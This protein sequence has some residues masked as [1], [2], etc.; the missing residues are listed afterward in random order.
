[1]RKMTV[2]GKLPGWTLLVPIAWCIASVAIVWSCKV[3]GV[4][5]DFGVPVGIACLLASVV[6]ERAIERKYLP[7]QRAN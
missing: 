3:A 6:I 4:L 2:E 7:K 1:M 5:W